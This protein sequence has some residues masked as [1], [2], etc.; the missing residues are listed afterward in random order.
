MSFQV[1][2]DI[3]TDVR[4]EIGEPMDFE[5]ARGA[6]WTKAELN[7]RINRAL[8][9]IARATYCNENTFERDIESGE[10]VYAVPPQ[11]LPGG[12]AYMEYRTTDD[13]IYPLRYRDHK[14]L[15]SWGLDTFDIPRFWTVWRNCYYL[16]PIP[17]TF[18]EN[19]PQL[20]V[21]FYGITEPLVEDTDG[22]ELHDA[23]HDAVVHRVA[24]W[25]LVGEDAARRADHLAAFR[26]VVAELN[27]DYR[28]RQFQ[29]PSD[30]HFEMEHL[31]D[32]DGRGLYRE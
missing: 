4:D 12:T 19:T 7:R 8:Q 26:E 30:M 21:R 1:L 10:Q 14:L 27:L 31:G 18:T 23:Y 24:Y 15:R 32:F 6:F 17:P 20:R 2:L 11:V 16:W 28:V 9:E 29:Q 5:G 3:R 25:C 13:T 22:L